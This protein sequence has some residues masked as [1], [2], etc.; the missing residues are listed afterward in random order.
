MISVIQKKRTKLTHIEF[1]PSH[2]VLIVG[3]DKGSILCLKLS[4]NL[5]RAL[6]VSLMVANPA[7]TN[8]RAHSLGKD[9]L[10]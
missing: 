4:P 1:N 7:V 8:L 2:P 10:S 6:K 3:D 5:R 9:L